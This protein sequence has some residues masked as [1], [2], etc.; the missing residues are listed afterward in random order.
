MVGVMSGTSVDGIDAALVRVGRTATGRYTAKVLHHVERA[1]PEELRGRLLGVMA[2]ARTETGEICELN[3]L[4]AREFAGA[5]ERLLKEAGVGREEIAG[6]G[7]HGQ[8]VCHLPGNAKRPPP[9]TRNAK[10]G[11]GGL[12]GSGSTLQLG[13]VSVIAALTGMVT[14]GDFR[15]ADMAVGGQGAP[16]VPWADAMLLRDGAKTRCVQNIGGIANVT[17]LPAGNAKR[18]PPETRNA[19]QEMEIPKSENRKPKLE[20]GSSHTDVIAFDTGPGN[21]V[22]DAVVSLATG[23]EERYDKD[24]RLAMRG[25]LDGALLKRLQGHSFFSQVPPKS[26]G[27]EDFGISLAEKLF[28]WA[29]KRKSAVENLVHTLARLTAWS[30][31]DA[32]SRFLPG[33]PEEVILCGGGA[34]N[35]VLVG[36]L[37]EELGE[38]GGAVMRRIDEFGIPNKAKEA[39]SFALLGAATLDG[40]PG[41]LPG[42]TG[43]KRA[44]VLGVVARP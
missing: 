5:V 20:V 8:T 36:L 30:I 16:L 34:D 14:V 4:V 7:S 40:V 44:V 11:I 43:A 19:K 15:A 38:R 39:A 1:W 37:R 3:F 2:P 12:R 32:Y 41:N 35:P 24:G 21:M 17:Y 23:G 27:R 9:E 33:M 28:R 13:D 26:T 18:P 42:V 31:A 22:M 6:I 25:K 10:R 29:G